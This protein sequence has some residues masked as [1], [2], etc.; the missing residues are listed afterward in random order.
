MLW[1]KKKKQA[2][3]IKSAKMKF[4]DESADEQEWKGISL[5]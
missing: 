5:F 1:G 2:S 3:K 4:L